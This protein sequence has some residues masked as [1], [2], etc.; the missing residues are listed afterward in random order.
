MRTLLRSSA[1]GEIAG[2]QRS[3]DETQLNSLLQERL[4]SVISVKEAWR[5]AQYAGR[6]AGELREAEQERMTSEQKLHPLA[7]SHPKCASRNRKRESP[8][9][10][11]AEHLKESGAYERGFDEHPGK[12]AAFCLTSRDHSAAILK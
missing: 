6:V 12:D 7:G 8:R 11:L 5:I 9:I 4:S 1:Y 2:E 10:N 3:F